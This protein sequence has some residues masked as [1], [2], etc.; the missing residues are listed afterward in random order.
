MFKAI[1]SSFFGTEK[2]RQNYGSDKNYDPSYE[3]SDRDHFLERNNILKVTKVAVKRASA[4]GYVDRHFLIKAIPKWMAEWATEKNIGDK[5]SLYGDWEAELGKHNREFLSYINDLIA[6]VISGHADG[7][8]LT[9]QREHFMGFSKKKSQLTADEFKNID[10]WAEYE[11][12]DDKFAK[13]IRPGSAMDVQ[14]HVHYRK[15]DR[16][17]DGLAAENPDDA[18]YENFSR[19]YDMSR[20]LGDG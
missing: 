6:P 15:H 12:V 14:R 5:E 8:P 19:G 13:R 17:M 3:M 16:D 20:I 7:I 2:H 9:R 10:V 11:V 18:S 4:S 1:I